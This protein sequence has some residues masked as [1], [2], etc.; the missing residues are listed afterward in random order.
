MVLRGVAQS[1]NFA[2]MGAVAETGDLLSVV[3]VADELGKPTRTVHY[4]I[5][6]GRIAA[7]KLGPGTSQYVITRE[8]VERV[9][10][11]AA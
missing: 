2:A 5:T 10:A 3:Q 11:A 7:T 1:R 6:T 8:E 9:K 4:W